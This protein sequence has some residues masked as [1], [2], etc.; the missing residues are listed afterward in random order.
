MGWLIPD[1]DPR[2]AL[3]LR[4]FFMGTSYYVIWL[5]I[6]GLMMYQGIL[7]VPI[8]LLTAEISGAVISNLVFYALLRSGVNQQLRDPSM[9]FAQLVVGLSWGMVLLSSAYV[10]RDLILI[11]YISPVFFGMFK[12]DQKGFTQLGLIAMGGYILVTALDFL[13]YPEMVDPTLQILRL[14]VVGLMLSWTSYFCLHVVRLKE[15]L[16]KQARDLERMVVEVTELAER[17]ELT[18]AYNRRF[19]MDSLMVEKSRSDRTGMPFSVC[20]LDLDHF[21]RINDRFG[22]IAGDG[23]LTSFA[24]KARSELRGLDLMGRKN[25]GAWFGRYGGE[26]FIIVLPNTSLLG[27]RNCAERI[28]H[29]TSDTSFDDVLRITVSGGVTEYRIGEDVEDTLRRADQ[30]LYNAKNGGRNQI[31]CAGDMGN[32]HVPSD[33]GS[34]VVIGLFGKAN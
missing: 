10:V 24:D 11:A 29:I 22:H 9:T 25:S 17:D 20:I 21:K 27:A 31:V 16:R 33:F 15:R 28:R 12:L 18:K 34:Q 23:V 32:T 6:V 19:I 1:E 26:E 8:P 13:V 7:H 30:A 3:R 4:R 2:Q 14:V 5:G